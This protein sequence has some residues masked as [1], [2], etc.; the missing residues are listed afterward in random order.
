MSRKM[1]L[2][3]IAKDKHRMPH[4]RPHLKTLALLVPMLM[5][6]LLPAALL[7]RTSLT[8]WRSARSALL[9]LDATQVELDR[10]LYWLDELVEERVQAARGGVDLIDATIAALR[11]C[12]ALGGTPAARDAIVDCCLAYRETVVLLADPEADISKA[13]VPLVEAVRA[14]NA[15]VKPAF[16]AEQS[17]QMSIDTGNVEDDSTAPYLDPEARRLDAALSE[18]PQMTL[19]D[20]LRRLEELLK[21]ETPAFSRQV[22]LLETANTLLCMAIYDDSRCY[23]TDID[24][25]MAILEAIIGSTDYSPV[26]ADAW[27]LWRARTQL[28]FFGSS[29]LSEIPNAMFNA[30]RVATAM[31]IERHLAAHPDDT[32]AMIQFVM[33]MTYPNYGRGGVFGHSGMGEVMSF[34]LPESQSSQDQAQ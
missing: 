17:L 21:D 23:E 20:R 11:D 31:V 29:N 12:Q 7:A 22:V 9:A 18:P 4:I 3:Q 19:A 8:A 34:L 25:G 10:Y 26:M 13:N 32:Q 30:Q 27:L 2:I 16:E 1:G 28:E 14:F 6:A 33:L 15:A 24:E 5:T